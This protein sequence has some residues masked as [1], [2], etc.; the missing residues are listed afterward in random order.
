MHAGLLGHDSIVMLG[1]AHLSPA[2]GAL[3]RSIGRIQ[4]HSKFRTMT[5]S[6]TS[7]DTANVFQLGPRDKAAMVLSS[8]NLQ[9]GV[10]VRSCLAVTATSSALSP[11]RSGRFRWNH[12]IATLFCT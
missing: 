2:M 11:K 3:I 8:P 5:L 6:A 12:P 9:K 4:N 10:S 7:S 1:E